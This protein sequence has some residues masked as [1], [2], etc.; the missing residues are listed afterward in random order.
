MIIFFTSQKIL[1]TTRLHLIPQKTAATERLAVFIRVVMPNFN[2][3]EE[4]LTL[5][6]IY[7]STKGTEIFRELQITILETQLDP[8]TLFA[9]ATDQYPS[10]LGVNQGLQGLINK[11]RKENDPALV[12]WH[13]CILHQESLA[14]KSLDIFNVTRVVI[15]K[16]IGFEQMHLTIVS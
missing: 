7:G 9:V 2:I 13:H 6:F 16:V 14:T 8:S 4:Y 5:R 11:W 15:S 1:F 12:T 10:M 3:Y